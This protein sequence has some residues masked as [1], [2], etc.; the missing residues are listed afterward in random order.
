MPQL[1]RSCSLVVSLA[2]AF[3]VAPRHVAAQRVVGQASSVNHVVFSDQN[4][5]DADW[6]IVNSFGLVFAGQVTTGGHPGSYRQV[7]LGVGQNIPF[8]GQLNRNF[9]YDPS[10]QG[11]VVGI[12]Y[13]IDL[14]TL[15]AEGATYEPLLQ[16]N[17]KLFI[18]AV[19]TGNATPNTWLN[20]NLVLN[21]TDFSE[22]TVGPFHNL[23]VD[24]NSKPDFS[25]GGS[26]LTFGY[27]VTAGGAGFF[28]SITGIDNDPITLD[29]IPLA[30][31]TTAPEPATLLLLAPALALVGWRA[32]RARTSREASHPC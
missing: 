15:N 26:P 9:V 23:V 20:E 2:A 10:A 5:D 31:P 30:P 16:Q 11:A 3:V 12:T 19:T 32:R 7:A 28:T 25:T 6:S 21:P 8:V 13:N 27:E 18:D 22:L 4:Y 14:E 1:L 24:V 17:G 29:I